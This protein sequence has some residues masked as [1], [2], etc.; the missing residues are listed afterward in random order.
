MN[1]EELKSSVLQWF[2]QEIE[3]SVSGPESLILTLPLLKPNGD[4]VELGIASEGNR[5]IVSDF[6]DTHSALELAGV[7]LNEE[8]VRAQ[9]FKQ[10]IR[11]HRIEET[12]DE[13]TIKVSRS[14]LV[15]R[16]FDFAQA[17]QS[18]LALQ[19][20]VKPKSMRRDFPVIVAKF[21]ADRR[22]SFEIP[23]ELILGRTGRWKFN[24]V[25]NHVHEETLVKAVSA[26]SGRHAL[27][28][29]EESVFEIKD[30]IAIRETKA[31]VI[32][33]DEKQRQFYWGQE[34]KR[35][36]EGYDVK[37][38]SFIENQRDLEQFAL[39]YAR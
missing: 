22:T 17:I 23:P 9:E 32:V 19:L 33:D 39:Q 3:C 15:E 36:F 8:L 10:I 31:I 13:M 12:S 38:F 30:V 24:F 34:A 18:M 35:V 25:L 1:C 6:G 27:K 16:V 21:L 20:T 37:M 11:A 28:L 26:S 29:A 2:G 7:D 4:P 14:D 5:W